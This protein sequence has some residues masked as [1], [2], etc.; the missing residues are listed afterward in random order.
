MLFFAFRQQWRWWWCGVV[1]VVAAVVVVWLECDV[2]CVERATGGESERASESGT[3]LC[4]LPQLFASAPPQGAEAGCHAE[5]HTRRAGGGRRG[6]CRTRPV[7]GYSEAGNSCDSLSPISALRLQFSAR[8]SS[9]YVLPGFGAR[10]CRV[11]R[12]RASGREGGARASAGEC[13]RVRP[14]RERRNG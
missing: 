14:G 5:T 10:P 3:L 4:V 2:G 9:H 8:A 6:G 12:A 7:C 13:V 11:P 1:V